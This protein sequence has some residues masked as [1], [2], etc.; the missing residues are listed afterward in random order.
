MNAQREE[1]EA[2]EGEHG[3]AEGIPTGAEGVPAGTEGDQAGRGEP[4]RK[5]MYL[6][7]WKNLS[8]LHNSWEMSTHLQVRKIKFVFFVFLLDL[9]FRWVFVLYTTVLLLC[10]AFCVVSCFVLF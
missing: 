10:V 8:Y 1:D 4:V 6:V 2:Q 9:C 3:G 5:E 7:K